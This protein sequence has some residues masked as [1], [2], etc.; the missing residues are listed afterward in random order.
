MSHAFTACGGP[1]LNKN[2]PVRALEMLKR[3]SQPPIMPLY[4][5]LVLLHIARARLKETG[6]LLY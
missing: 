3:F 5:F 6:L 1:S 4:H 2:F